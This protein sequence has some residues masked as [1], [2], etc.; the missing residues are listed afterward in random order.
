[1]LRLRTC[2]D[3]A[4]LRSALDGASSLIVVGG[5]FI[6]CEVAANGARHGVDVHL[7]APEPQPLYGPLGDLVATEVRRRLDQLGVQFQLGAVP[8]RYTGTDSA[9]GIDLS[10]LKSLRGDVIVEAVGS[11]PNTEWL[12]GN[13]LDLRNG[14]ITD[15]FLRVDGRPN[16]VACGDVATFPLPAFGGEPAR[17]EHW[18]VAVETARCAGSNLGAELTDQSDNAAAVDLAPSFW[19]HLD[20]TRLQAFGRPALGRGDVRVLE[21]ELRGEAA[22][23]YHRD[24]ALVGVVLLGMA[25]R[26]AHYLHEITH[27]ARHLATR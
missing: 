19:S 15:E 20:T 3:A 23:G 9:S 16:V 5:G 24:G 25:S 11:I 27:T 21:G 10:N 17:L 22:V 13:G 1:V 14:V 12:I 7:V 8:L 4:V 2:D 26:Y 6:G 18:T